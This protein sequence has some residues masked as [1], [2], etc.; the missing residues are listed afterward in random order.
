MAGSRATRGSRARAVRTP[1][2]ASPPTSP[3]PE[4]LFDAL[5]HLGREMRIEMSEEELIHR[6]VRFAS[7]LL[8][9]RSFCVRL[10]D[11]ETFE[12]SLV[13]ATGRLVAGKREP[14]VATRAA[15]EAAAITADAAK[16][17]GLS[18]V[19][20][21]VPVF[22]RQ[23]EGFDVLLARGGR[24]YG[25]LNVEYA[26]RA[27]APAED[28]RMLHPLAE[29]LAGALRN[30]Q[31]LRESVYL[32]SYLEKLLDHANAVIVVVG[33]NRK[34][35]VANRALEKLTGRSREELLDSDFLD[36]LPEGERARVLPAFVR[37]LRGDASAHIEVKIP[38]RRG[39]VSRIAFNTAP[40]TSPDGEI[41]GLIAI[42]Q[43]LTELRLLQD[44]VIQAE[45]LATLGQLAAGVVHE[46][47]NPLTSISVYSD[48]LIKKFERQKGDDGDLEKLRRIL[49]GAERILKFTRDLTSYA[50]PATDEPAVL[51][52]HA[53]LD[54]SATFCEHLIEDGN[55]RLERRYA[56]KSPKVFG[57]AAQLHQVFINLI[58]NAC[59]AMTAGE[60]RLVV[61]TSTDAEGVRIVVED[62]G[63][64]IG[65]E[66]LASV[67]EPF[68]TTKTGGKGTGLGLSIVR[69]I[70]KNHAGEVL[71]RS[72]LGRGTTVS[73]LLPKHGD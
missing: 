44:Q 63:C 13:Y 30:A 35:Q 71:V 38:G 56:E 64:G 25:L 62:N 14:L 23:A 28:S 52:L 66:D 57:I 72:D 12:L 58:T 37:T 16:R 50:R 68:F 6:F 33:R 40:I 18:L 21:Y 19:E 65:A 47:N 20:R 10:L 70:V 34:V 31:V 36:L 61:R 67:F 46:L 45:K 29:L 2:S 55:M 39:G 1:R 48:Y 51:D 17:M 15:A 27:T 42:G 49:Q 26:P 9:E 8:P 69:N 24:L 32:R 73:I 53:I 59:H 54:Q 11:P 5:V 4:R 3:T 22:D 7:E 43:D 41:E 60:G